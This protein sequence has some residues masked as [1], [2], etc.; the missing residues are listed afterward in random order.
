M[1]NQAGDDQNPDRKGGGGSG[2]P[3]LWDPMESEVFGRLWTLKEASE[4]DAAGKG[5][6]KAI[7]GGLASVSLLTH[8][9][10][11]FSL[12]SEAG[13]NLLSGGWS[14]A[15][16]SFMTRYELPVTL[17]SLVNPADIDAYRARLVKVPYGDLRSPG[18]SAIK[19]TLPKRIPPWAR[20]ELWRQWWVL[21]RGYPG[22][23]SKRKSVIWRTWALRTPRPLF[24]KLHHP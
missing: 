16:G 11:L 1:E 5:N 19:T 18:T 17:L 21:W 3:E 9:L 2:F 8:A 20:G 7:N 13:W 12:S 14:Q 22:I 24:L 15:D 23:T 6:W 4:G 10:R